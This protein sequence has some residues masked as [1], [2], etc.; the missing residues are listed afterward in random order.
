MVEP[1]AIAGA[2]WFV[3]VLW[4]LDGTATGSVLVSREGWRELGDC[5]GKISEYQEKVQAQFRSPG[6]LVCSL[7]SERPLEG[8]V[9]SQGK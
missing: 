6:L 5:I 2:K 4:L 8:M 3:V 1:L 9:P 7:I